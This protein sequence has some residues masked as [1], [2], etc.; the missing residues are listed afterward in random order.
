MNF[1]LDQMA[2]Y[3]DEVKAA[4]LRVIDS[5]WYLGGEETRKFEQEWA[6][7]TRQKYAVTVGNGTDAI[8][9]ALLAFG[10]GPGDEVL[11]PAF[12][13]GFTALAIRATG[14]TPVFVDSEHDGVQPALMDYVD[15]WTPKTRAIVPVDIF[16]GVHKETPTL[17]EWARR[18]GLV[19]VEDAAHAHGNRSVGYGDAT[20]YSFYPTKNLG[21]LGE[22]GAVTTNIP[23][24]A[25]RI[26]LLRDGGRTDRYV[27][28]PPGGL[29][30]MMDEVQ[31]AVLRVKLPY[32]DFNN[33]LREHAVGTY[34]KELE[35]V[36]EV[37]FRRVNKEDVH[38]LFVIR[39]KKRDELHQFLK[40]K[41]IPTLIHY[42]LIVPHQPLFM[43]ENLSKGLWP[44]AE[45]MSRDT[46]SLPLHP[47]IS[48][49]DVL[50]V[51]GAIYEFYS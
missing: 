18:K 9:I 1:N 20:A 33:S 22:A 31:A 49:E 36:N 27:H 50:K 11:T 21:A 5:G 38:H 45:A 51:T 24:I 19:V 32:L 37:R 34:T 42:P 17:M 47:D 35:P 15:K 16:G 14:A 26:R 3:K 28:E 10:I 4:V 29:N 25:E 44:N 13:V 43:G 2:P 12:C 40:G 46:L 6:A 41:G 23:V 48:Y 39:T 8:R 30:S 7:Y